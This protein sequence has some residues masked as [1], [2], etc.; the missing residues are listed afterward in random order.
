[1]NED[2]S[3][4]ST[5]EVF[6][7]LREEAFSASA[8]E[9]LYNRYWY[10][11]FVSAMKR[12]RNRAVA[13]EVVQDFFADLW[14]K[15]H[16]VSINSSFEGYMYSAIRY[17]ILDHFQKELVRNVYKGNFA[18]NFTENDSSTE[19]SIFV[20]DIERRVETEV[21][22][23]PDKCRSVY[24]LSRKENMSNKEIA[25]LM[26]ISEKTVENH[27]NKALRRIRL[28]LNEVVSVLLVL[29]LK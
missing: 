24:E 6:S 18:R 17:S 8:F 11:L 15:R 29:L 26:N 21:K 28:S 5:G 10:K 20:H 14:I 3:T 25:S 23:L 13:E 2:V 19:H 22:L 16:S 12:V 1:M 4:L 7:L 27:I 9:E